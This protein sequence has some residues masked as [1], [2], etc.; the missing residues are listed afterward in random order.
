MGLTQYFVAQNF[1]KLFILVFTEL[2]SNLKLYIFFVK[3]HEAWN[4][5]SEYVFVGNVTSS[6]K[7]LQQWRVIGNT[8]HCVFACTLFDPSLWFRWLGFTIKWEK[9]AKLIQNPSKNLV[10]YQKNIANTYRNIP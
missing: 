1:Y 3:L 5:F 8:L 10:Y 2:N 7:M 6:E 4:A 9:I